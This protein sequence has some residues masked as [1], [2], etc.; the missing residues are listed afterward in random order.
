MTAILGFTDLL[1][2]EDSL[3]DLGK[4]RVDT[5][6]RNGRHLLTI[7]NDILDVSK[8]EAG[9]MTTECMECSVNSVVADMVSLLR[10]KALTKGLQLSVEYD[11]GIPKNIQS[12]PTRLRQILV[13]LIGNAIKFTEKGQIKLA[14]RLKPGTGLGKPQLQFDV[15][16][17]GIGM[18]DEQRESVFQ[19]FTQADETMTRRFGGTGLGLTISQG[20]ARL[21]GGEL[22][23]QSRLGEGTTISLTVD[24]GSLDGV[25]ML[26][27]C[28]EI[29]A[30]LGL[31][32]TDSVKK[33]A[34]VMPKL[35]GRILLVED[36]IDNQRLI[37]FLLTK[38]GADVALAENGEIGRDKALEAFNAGEP[39][40][41]IFMDMQMPILDGYSATEQLRAADYRLPIVALTAHAMSHD[42]TK[43]MGSGCDDFITK[44]INRME[45]VSM[46]AKWMEKSREV[47][48]V[49]NEQVGA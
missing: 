8:I 46:A 24:T 38:A 27:E 11:G 19:A 14:V 1:K 21:L 36:G 41:L 34:V 32:I 39:F 25:P 30:E 17:T 10:P 45:L 3:T 47:D 2:E 42:R 5:I 43:C 22:A 18:T 26:T 6:Q 31:A 37:S 23:V 28:S 9:K 33:P 35:S 29:L 7:I 40:D 12:D 44:P 13:N 4:E 48:C 16:D 15:V 20:L 49:G